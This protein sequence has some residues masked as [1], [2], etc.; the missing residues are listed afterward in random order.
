MWPIEYRKPHDVSFD[1][2]KSLMRTQITR[3]VGEDARDGSQVLLHF[4]VH[5]PDEKGGETLV[6]DSS[7]AA[8][9]G[10]RF[11]MGETLHAEVLERGVLGMPP[12]SV[13]NVICTD[14]DAGS[15]TV[16][17]IAPPALGPIATEKVIMI[18]KKDFGAK[19]GASIMP[20]RN[21]EL[22]DEARAWIAPAS[23]TR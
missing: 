16:L 11:T 5:A 17:R 22:L 9:S 23:M 4:T 8:P 20:D 6:Y 13:V 1:K 19:I 10:L 2:N 3:G 7:T 21:K 18:S 12:G 14:V 15:D